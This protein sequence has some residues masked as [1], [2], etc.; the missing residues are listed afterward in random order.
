MADNNRNRTD[1]ESD[2]AREPEPVD[3]FD[4]WDRQL[5]FERRSRLLSPVQRDEH[6]KAN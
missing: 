1:T 3:F 5:S 4:P 6:R 2:N